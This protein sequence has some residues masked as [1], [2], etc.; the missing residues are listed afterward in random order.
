MYLTCF[1]VVK[2]RHHRL[3]AAFKGNV[4]FYHMMY[5]KLT[6]VIMF[7]LEISISETPIFSLIF[8]NTD[9]SVTI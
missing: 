6:Y 7:E 9:I 5:R 1:G 3:K 4:L 2:D 8:F